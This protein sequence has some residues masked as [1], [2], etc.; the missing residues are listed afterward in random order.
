MVNSELNKP[1]NREPTVGPWDNLHADRCYG[2]ASPL[3]L[4]PLRVPLGLALV[5]MRLPLLLALLALEFL[6][7]RLAIV[8]ARVPTKLGD[9]P[10]ALWR[11]AIIRG[12]TRVLQVIR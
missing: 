1:I 9:V 7:F 8:G 6:V 12:A 10:L 4:A 2:L 5:L 11:V 3:W